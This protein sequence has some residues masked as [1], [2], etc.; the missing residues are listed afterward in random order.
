VL[1]LTG[2]GLTLRDALE[3]AAYICGGQ[4]NLV[5][6][7]AKGNEMKRKGVK[8]IVVAARSCWT[9]EKLNLQYGGIGDVSNSDSS[10]EEE[11]DGNDMQVLDSDSEIARAGE[12]AGIRIAVSGLEDKSLEK[13]LRVTLIRNV[14]MKQRV[15]SQALDLLKYSRNLQ[16]PAD[17][18]DSQTSFLSLPMEIQL[19]VFS[20]IAPLLSCTQRG[21]VI[22]YAVDRSTLPQ[23]PS[24]PAS[25]NSNAESGPRASATKVKSRTKPTQVLEE[26]VKTSSCFGGLCMTNRTTREVMSRCQK[27]T[28]RVLWLEKFLSLSGCEAYDPRIDFVQG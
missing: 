20:Y 28:D 27:H 2:T 22:G 19:I 15:A 23:F 21:R 9:L 12:A 16:G 25:S 11:T 3:L 7:F 6:L 1:D 4:C 24:G 13:A 18:A 17:T 26:K 10:Q 5:E 14:F 8:A